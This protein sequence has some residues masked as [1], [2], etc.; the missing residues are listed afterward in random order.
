MSTKNH[1]VYFAYL[2]TSAHVFFAPYSRLAMKRERDANI[3]GLKQHNYN[4]CSF[5][6]F[7][8]HIV[9]EDSFHSFKKKTNNFAFNHFC[10]LFMSLPG[11]LGL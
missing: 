7:N 2:L 11:E 3:E 1:V 10:M 5:C 8:C 9:C 4:Q 6:S